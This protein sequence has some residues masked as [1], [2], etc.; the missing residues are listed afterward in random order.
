MRRM[1]PAELAEQVMAGSRPHIAR[2]ITLVESSRGDHREQAKEL[3]RLLRPASGSS[4]RVGIT[5]VP[6][7]GK[8]TFIDALGVR[9]IGAGHR[10]AVLA[11]DP[12]FGKALLLKGVACH[13]FL[14]R[15]NEG[16]T[17][18][19]EFV[20]LRPEVGEGHL[21]LGQALA[22]AGQPQEARES[23]QRAAE[24]TLH[25][26]KE[27]G[28]AQW[29]LFEQELH[30]RDRRRFGIGAGIGGGLENGQF[31]VDYEPTVTLDEGLRRTW[32]AR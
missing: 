29:M 31:G 3:L 1:I 19:R 26:A 8:S 9:L 17:L 5:G 32:A 21:L 11:V 4:V 7:A 22:S 10:I 18:L 30:D 20:R 6:G 14:R 15:T 24:L 2:A 28:K 13:R 12:T 23:L 16:M 27:N 25:R